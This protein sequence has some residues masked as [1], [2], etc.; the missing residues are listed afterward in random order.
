MIENFYK[1][2]YWIFLVESILLLIGI[3]LG[4]I[5]YGID[6]QTSFMTIGI[7]IGILS[8]T[9]IKLVF[10]KLNITTKILFASIMLFLSTYY[11]VEDKFH[12]LICS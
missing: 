2:V 12:I 10:K 1:I 3:N 9:I 11:L 8:G 7:F 6:V 4:L 5:S